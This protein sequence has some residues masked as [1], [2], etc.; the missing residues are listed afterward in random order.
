MNK[1]EWIVSCSGFLIQR[2]GLRLRKEATSYI[3][4]A[5][6]LLVWVSYSETSSPFERRYRFD[7]FYMMQCNRVGS[8]ECT[9]S[10]K[11]KDITDLHW[12]S[13]SETLSPF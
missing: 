7:A 1:N 6:L 3:N 12:L 5:V 10:K 8:Q 11:I 13:D 4:V 9:Y 2:L